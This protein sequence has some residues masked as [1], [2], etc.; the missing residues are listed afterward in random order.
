MTTMSSCFAKNFHIATRAE[1]ENNPMIAMEKFISNETCDEGRGKT[2]V[3]QGL[4]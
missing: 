4:S 3:D 1:I 2:V